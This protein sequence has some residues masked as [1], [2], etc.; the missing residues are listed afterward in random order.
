[1]RWNIRYTA[2]LCII[3]SFCIQCKENPYKS[4]SIKKIDEKWVLHVAEKDT[5]LA[6][7]IPSNVHSDLHQHQLIEDPFWENNEQKLQWI[8]EE[9]WIYSTK[10]QLTEEELSYGFIDIVFEGSSERQ[11]LH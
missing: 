10:F 5:F 4:N 8:E 11:Q 1:M 6:V 3:I 9:N 2:A 7:N